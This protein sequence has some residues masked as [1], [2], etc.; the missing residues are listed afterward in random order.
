MWFYQFIS[1]NCDS[2]SKGVYDALKNLFYLSQQNFEN[3]HII[4]V[5]CAC[6]FGKKITNK[7]TKG[8]GVVGFWGFDSFTDCSQQMKLIK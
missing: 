1:T 7:R 3:K 6:Y 5:I 2:Y 4:Q 8:I